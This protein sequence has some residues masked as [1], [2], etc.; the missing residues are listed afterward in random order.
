MINRENK[1]IN[2]T[3]YKVNNNVYSRIKTPKTS[4]NPK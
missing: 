3:S 4:F 1:K 2:C